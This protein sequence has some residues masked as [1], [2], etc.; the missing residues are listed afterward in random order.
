MLSLHIFLLTPFV[1]YFQ[2]AECRNFRRGSGHM[3][4]CLLEHIDNITESSCKQFLLKMGSI[5]FSDYRLVSNF[6][7]N[8]Q[9]DI[10]RL[11]C[12]RVQLEE[13]DDVCIY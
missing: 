5:I 2:I 8:C 7:D 4:P 12:G 11:K 3:I 10:D 1:F 9:Q 13:E 6:V